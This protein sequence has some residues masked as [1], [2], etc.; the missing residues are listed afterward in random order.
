MPARRCWA[1]PEVLRPAAGCT[2]RLTV[3]HRG[4]QPTL[5]VAGLRQLIGGSALHRAA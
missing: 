3:V 5:V 4:L 2:V 1:R